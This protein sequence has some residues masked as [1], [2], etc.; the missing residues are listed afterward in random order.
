MRYLINDKFV[1]GNDAPILFYC[2]NEGDV[3]KYYANSGFMTDTLA[4]SMKALILFG[5]HR[6]Y[7]KSMPFGD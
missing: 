1:E 4:T 7:G 6:Y 2:G 5:E 3:E